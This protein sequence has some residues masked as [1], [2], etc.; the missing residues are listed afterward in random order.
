VVVTPPAATFTASPTPTN[1]DLGTVTI[2]PA[3][4]TVP[5]P[6]P[7]QAPVTSVNQLTPASS[8]GGDIVRIEPGPGGVF[9]NFVYAISRGAGEN[10][11]AVNRP[12]VIYRVDPATGNTS[13][14]F[15]LNTVV[16]QEQPPAASA[17]NSVTTASGLV[18]WYDIAF[19]PEGYFTGQPAM[20][21]ASVDRSNP[22]LNAVYEIGP[23][24]QLVA[25]FTQ[26]TSGQPGV[27]FN[28]NPSAI[29]VMPPQDQQFL[30]GLF[31]GSGSGSSTTAPP[32]FTALFFNANAYSPGTPISSTTLPAGVS[33]TNLGL[34]PQVG[35]TD[36]NRDY[37]SQVY[38]AYTDFG[39][40]AGPG[41]PAVPGFSGV[42]GNSNGEQLIGP[43]ATTTTATAL[44]LDQT[45]A[46]PTTGRRFEDIAFDEYQYF[47]Q[48]VPLTTT[49]TNGVT[50]F[51]VG[52]PV[53]AGSVFVA[54]LA[55]GLQVTVTPR[56]PFTTTAINVPV[57]GPGEVGV[58]TD[59][60]GNVVPIITNGNTTGGS[61][62]GGR[63]LRITPSGQVTVF[64]D[65]FDTSGAQDSTSFI[66][67]SLS[68]GFSADGTTLYASDD[69]G[70][71]Q[72]KTTADL[73]SSTSGSLIGLNDLR[74]LGV[75]YDGLGAAVAVVDTGVDA[76]STPFRGRV[77]PGTN[78]VTNGLGNTD[79][80]STTG[81]TTT[82]GTGAGTT[83]ANTFI[84]NGVDGHGTLIAGVVA[85]FVPQSTIDP[86]NIFNPFQSL[87]GTTGTTT[88]VAGAAALGF[89]S[90]AATSSQN[91][92]N[93][94]KYVADHP[95]VNDPVRPNKADRVI[96]ATFGFGSQTT[97]ASERM[98][99]NQFPQLIITLKNQF[100]RYRSLG[101]A[102]IAAAGQFGN[103][104]ADSSGTTGAAGATTGVLGANNAGNN[105]VGD[106]NGM[107]LPAALNEVISVTGVIPFP[108]V[109]TAS[110][111]PTDPPI[112]VTPS[113][114]QPVLIGAGATGTTGTTAGTTSG[115]PLSQ[116]LLGNTQISGS[117]TGGATTTTTTGVF[118]NGIPQNLYADRVLA[119]ANRSVTTDFAAP[120]V[121]IPT[122]RRT[123]NLATAATTT[124]TTATTTDPLDHLTFT[125]GG[126][127]LSAGI[128]AGSYGLVSSALNYWINLNTTGVTSD[129][130]LTGPVGQT[131]LNFRPHPFKDLS[132]YNNPDGINAILAWTSVPVADPNDGLSQSQPPYLI[133]L[134]R[135]R[136]LARVSVGNAIAA[137]EG[138][139]AIQY[140][141]DHK[142][143]PII[144][145]NHNGIITAQELQTF[146]N[147]A[148]AMGLPEAGAMARLL[149]GTATTPAATP[150]ILGEQPDQPGALQ[151]R[152]NFFDYSADGHLNGSVTI[153]QFKMLAHTLLPLPDAY[154]VTD[155]QRA[156]ANGFLVDP[157]AIRNFHDLQHLLP[158]FEFVPKGALLKYR[159]ISPNT[160]GI[161]R[162]VRNVDAAN[163]QFP[164]WTLFTDA[165]VHS[166][167]TSA[168][169]TAPATASAGNTSGT[170]LVAASSKASPTATPTPS[171]TPTPT[172]S[173]TGGTTAGTQSQTV[174][175]ASGSGNTTTN[176]TSS[177]NTASTGSS[178]TQPQ[179]TPGQ[180]AASI[181]LNASTSGS[182]TSSST[183]S[184]SSGS[185]GS[186]TSSTG[187]SST[188]SSAG[189]SSS[190]STGTIGSGSAGSS[191]SGSTGTTGSGSA[192]SSSSGSTGTTG[193]GSTGTTGS[194]STGTTGSGS[195]GTSSS[196]STGTSSSTSGSSNGKNNGTA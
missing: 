170:A 32:T 131:T 102:P 75:P 60:A 178:T 19:D 127:S 100:K 41:I 44:T 160:F 175:M 28:V 134:H 150:S 55:T 54:D 128:V 104:L 139:E 82:T 137:I 24:A 42:Q 187:G 107:S 181:I 108:W 157:T 149:G 101:I 15:D 92:Y 177:S 166:S 185:A 162:L 81:S 88:G 94:I 69:Q 167:V 151:R 121:D 21:V 46:V 119:S 188:S 173:T 138:T 145:T 174:S 61:N 109:D 16:T 2:A 156:S 43:P 87:T 133:G 152:F 10:V 120:A 182:S 72:F 89:N 34:G 154:T 136:D 158:Q 90:N 50:T 96:S 74:T 172:T 186:S 132:A 62:I 184:S 97:F 22:N 56:A 114:P 11:G 27:K 71:W 194:G 20:Y 155:R 103:P 66:D 105:N 112:G 35:I 31:T 196:G 26:F 163:S 13:V 169:Q 23:N 129:A 110:T 171:P 59:A 85:Q 146:E 193:G 29:F 115:S 83:S 195:T 116:L 126:T 17:A 38:S 161:N 91:V 148:S 124:A 191:S 12:G 123:F 30:R 106:S 37:L 111:I 25:V 98:A 164:I 135:F 140:L 189:S 180:Q 143:F 67:S 53:F 76:N 58:T 8:F 144:D 48:G 68:I 9:G 117:T 142:D 77:A 78:V 5:T 99:Y 141:I 122:F 47:S 57:Q 1:A 190:G 65:N 153:A 3:T 159:N 113:P 79:T 33:M 14:F 45:P 84:S 93:G 63:I 86:V 73:A 49:T 4:T 36:A 70:I 39:T 51:G 147:N 40:P 52:S 18:N 179:Q 168:T 118:I 130:Y 183:G 192:G 176:A 80:A 125:E 7:T 6:Y 165:G 64:A 95:F